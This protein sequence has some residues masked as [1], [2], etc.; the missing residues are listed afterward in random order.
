M[1]LRYYA[2]H[3]LFSFLIFFFLITRP[4]P[5]STQRSTLF[6][7]TTLFRATDTPTVELD[8][9]TYMEIVRNR[10]S[11]SSRN[12]PR[13]DRVLSIEVATPTTAH[14]RV[15]DAVLPK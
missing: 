9:P 11:P 8:L 4:P 5:I 6:P 13:L 1:W 7:Y 14:V 3:F 2:S 15:Q 12:D 10:P